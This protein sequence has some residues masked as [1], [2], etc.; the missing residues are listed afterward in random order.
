MCIENYGD[1]AQL[2]ERETENLG[3]GGSTPPVPTTKGEMN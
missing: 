3:V 2:V 1:V